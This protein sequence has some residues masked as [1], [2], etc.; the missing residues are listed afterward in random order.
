MFK[1]TLLRASRETTIFKME[2]F[3]VSNKAPKRYKVGKDICIIYR[4]EPYLVNWNK[5]VQ[6]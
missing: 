1:A 3:R 6:I 2:W 4:I 5:E